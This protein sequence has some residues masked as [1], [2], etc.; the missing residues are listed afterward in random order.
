MRSSV[1]LPVTEGGTMGDKSSQVALTASSLGNRTGCLDG[2]SHQFFVACIRENAGH[3]AFRA[4][5]T[6]VA[7]ITIA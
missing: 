5:M 2:T 4:A 6:E 3:D 7:A 1:K